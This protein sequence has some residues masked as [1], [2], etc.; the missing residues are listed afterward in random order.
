MPDG[1]LYPV[2]IRS[3]TT[4]ANFGQKP[5]KYAPPRGFKSLSSAG[6]KPK[7]VISNPANFVE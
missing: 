6:T 2:M 3:A 7:T 1:E 4:V 5:F